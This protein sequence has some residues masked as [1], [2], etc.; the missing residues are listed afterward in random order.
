MDQ[1]TQLQTDNSFKECER[2][3]ALIATAAV[4]DIGRLQVLPTCSSVRRMGIITSHV[5]LCASGVTSSF[6]SAI[7]PAAL[8]FMWLLRSLI[9]SV[10]DGGEPTAARVSSQVVTPTQ[11]CGL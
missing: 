3:C 8:L 11:L 7:N 4:S 2:V 6:L 10:S 9:F 1:N 5:R